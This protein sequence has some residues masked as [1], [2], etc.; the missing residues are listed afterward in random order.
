MD[1]RLLALVDG[2]VGC[3]QVSPA[4]GVADGVQSTLESWN[5]PSCLGEDNTTT[6]L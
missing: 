5:V 4:K 6:F 1:R 3:V 2:N